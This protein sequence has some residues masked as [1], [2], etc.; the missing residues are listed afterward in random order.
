M[1]DEEQHVSCDDD[2]PSSGD[3]VPKVL[4]PWES[5]GALAV[6]SLEYTKHPLK[7]HFVHGQ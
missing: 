3:I 7:G 5:D 4:L 1:K 6:G 2:V